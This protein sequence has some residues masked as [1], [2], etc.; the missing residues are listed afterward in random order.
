MKRFWLSFCDPKKPEGEQFLGVSIVEA[1]HFTL[2]AP[3][4]WTLGCNPCGEVQITELPP[5]VDFHASWLGRLIDRA[6]IAKHDTL[7]GW[8]A[9]APWAQN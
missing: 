4:A 9:P 6:T 7:E 3:T 5:D 2:A 8:A 1:P